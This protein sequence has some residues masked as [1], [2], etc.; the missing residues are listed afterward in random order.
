MYGVMYS[1]PS[2]QLRERA[3]EFSLVLDDVSI[4]DLSFGSEFTAAIEAKQVA[5]QNAQRAALTVEKARQEKMQKIVE[6]QGEAKSIELV[7]QVR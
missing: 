4:T 1:I 2:D 7:G 6:A 5:Q 3:K